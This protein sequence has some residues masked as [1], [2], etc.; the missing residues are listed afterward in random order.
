MPYRD[1]NTALLET[2]SKR[3]NDSPVPLSFDS[4]FNGTKEQYGF[5]LHSP[6]PND[7]DLYKR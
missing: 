3:A 5:E 4:M 6:E 1:T 2:E 7:Y